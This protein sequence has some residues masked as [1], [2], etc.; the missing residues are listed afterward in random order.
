MRG[1][2]YVVM[3]RRRA[4]LTQ[5][6]LAAALG[7]RQATI[8]RWERA[9][10]Q[11]GFEELEAVAAA[12]GLEFQTRLGVQ[13]RSWWPQIAAQ[14]A[15]EPA[16]R[17]QQLAGEGGDGL[18]AVLAQLA[19]SDSP[20]VVIGAVAAALQGAPLVL[21]DRVVEVG[22]D[23]GGR[24]GTVK[25]RCGAWA[26]RVVTQPPGTRGFADL[27]R[28]AD[29]IDIDGQPV[30]VASL[31]DLIRIADASRDPGAEL[32]AL[33]CRAV[34]DVQRAQ[35]AEI[36]DGATAD[37]RITQWLARQTPIPT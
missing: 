12:C 9:D 22:G 24:I 3:A 14:L 18:M 36:R 32:Q 20:C 37:E 8:A 26:V 33:A 23:G 30:L 35:P 31:L 5:R 28:A 10:R 29:Q 2:D 6:E 13:D 27:V 16:R 4:G 1:A 7:C 21:G 11:V 34:L 19:D 17:V 25:D 15:L